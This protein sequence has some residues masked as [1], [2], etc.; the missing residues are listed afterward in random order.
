LNSAAPNRKWGA[1][2]GDAPKGQQL[3]TRLPLGATHEGMVFA[4]ENVG[5]GKGWGHLGNRVGK[6]RAAK[7]RKTEKSR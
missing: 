7:K 1:A 4:S 2:F 3:E 6:P 5:T